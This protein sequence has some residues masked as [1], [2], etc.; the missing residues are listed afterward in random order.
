MSSCEVEGVRTGES[1][2]WG[3]RRMSSWEGR[4]GSGEVGTMVAPNVGAWG[5]WAMVG[6]SSRVR[7]W[8]WW[9]GGVMWEY[10]SSNGWKAGGLRTAGS[11]MDELSELGSVW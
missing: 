1:S 11:E 5:W 3:G 8:W 10:E 9:C 4:R 2:I 7:G 6:G